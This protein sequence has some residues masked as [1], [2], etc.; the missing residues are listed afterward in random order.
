MGYG[1]A[2]LVCA[3]KLAQ[4]RKAECRPPLARGGLLLVEPPT[5]RWAAAHPSHLTDVEELHEVHGRMV[6]GNIA[7]VKLLALAR[8]CTGILK[9]YGRTNSRMLEQAPVPGTAKAKTAQG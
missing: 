3:G 9:Q 7:Y 2:L 4:L 1:V 6:G 8:P 5:F